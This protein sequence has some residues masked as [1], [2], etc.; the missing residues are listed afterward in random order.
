MSQQAQAIASPLPV[1]TSLVPGS[2]RAE[3]ETRRAAGNT[4]SVRE[5][6]GLIVP[7]CTQLA[8]AHAPGKV[9]FVHPSTIE[10]IR[11]GEAQFVEER[12]H[13]APTLPRDRSCLAPEA[14]KGEAGDAR[15]SVFT[16]GAILYELITNGSVGPG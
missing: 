10:Y 6:L 15:A 16:I 4:F 3:M 13:V 11:A 1:G 5:A 12:A 9:F 7:L 2:L 14:R 8:A